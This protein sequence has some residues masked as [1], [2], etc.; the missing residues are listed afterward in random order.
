M[1]KRREGRGGERVKK[2]RGAGEERG[3]EGKGGEG[4]EGKGREGKGREGKG[5]EGKGREG[6]GR[7]GKGVT[8]IATESQ[9][10][11]ISKSKE[12]CQREREMF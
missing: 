7:E 6:K 11:G 4:R 12:T 1:E 9:S 2:G 8:A 10:E 3:G 5:R